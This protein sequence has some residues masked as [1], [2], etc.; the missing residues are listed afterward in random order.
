MAAGIYRPAKMHFTNVTNIDVFVIYHIIV[1]V[2]TYAYKPKNSNIFL[3][4]LSLW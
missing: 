1:T 3:S 4:Q 2:N